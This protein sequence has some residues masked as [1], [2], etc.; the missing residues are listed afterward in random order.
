VR[1]VVQLS[2]LVVKSRAIG[3]WILNALAHSRFSF[4]FKVSF[5]LLAPVSDAIVTLLHGD[6][7]ISVPLVI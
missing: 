3:Q 4:V 6:M 7:K 2:A 5:P 1:L